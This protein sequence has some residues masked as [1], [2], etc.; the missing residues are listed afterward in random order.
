M[1]LA[2]LE[3][4]PSGLGF[5]MLGFGFCGV[6]EHSGVWGRG[7]GLMGKSA[8]GWVKM[9]KVFKDAGSLVFGALGVDLLVG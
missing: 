4:S 6:Q 3:I 8:L 1:R 2:R 5:G 9:A 7:V